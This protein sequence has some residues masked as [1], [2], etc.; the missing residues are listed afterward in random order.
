MIQIGKSKKN[1]VDCIECG[2]AY[3]SRRRDL[4]YF[5]CLECGDAKA[6][7]AINHKKKCS[8]PLFNKGAYQYVGSREEAR[9]IG[10]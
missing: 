8:A 1:T 10:R 2:E 7:E 6:Q 9:W 5:T 3:N 4:G